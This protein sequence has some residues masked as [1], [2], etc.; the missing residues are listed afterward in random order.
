M[1][2]TGLIEDRALPVNIDLVYQG[3]GPGAISLNFWD[4]DRYSAP[5]RRRQRSHKL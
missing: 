3:I 1:T 2:I 4:S 5:S